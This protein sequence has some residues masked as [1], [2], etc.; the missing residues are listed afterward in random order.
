MKMLYF[1]LVHSRIQYLIANWG[2]ACKT[3]LRGLQ[4]LQNR[5]LKIISRKPALFPTTDLY[6]DMTDSVLPLKA[7][8]ELQTTVQ[9]RKYSTD[10]TQHHNFKL[11]VRVSSRTTRQQGEFVLDRPYSEFGRK[12][13]TYFGGKLYNALSRE[14]KQS[15]TL[16]AFKRRLTIIIKQNIH[17]Y[18]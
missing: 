6:S 1:S 8:Y 10:A 13:F 12:K 17:Q 11:Q 4:V 7:L 2:S 5:C 18:V 3:D 9:I 16:A 15:P 14:C